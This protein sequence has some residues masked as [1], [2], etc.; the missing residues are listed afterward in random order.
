ML[1]RLLKIYLIRATTCVHHVSQHIVLVASRSNDFIFAEVV[2]GALPGLDVRPQTYS[3]LGHIGQVLVD[4]LVE[5][6]ICIIL[7]VVIHTIAKA[8]E[9]TEEVL[10]TCWLLSQ[11]LLWLGRPGELVHLLAVQ[12]TYLLPFTL[13]PL[14]L[15]L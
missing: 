7:Q 12:S 9:A 10:Q 14:F 6:S 4:H 3:D 1:C 15:M 13:F 11:L 5:D 8:I 2:V